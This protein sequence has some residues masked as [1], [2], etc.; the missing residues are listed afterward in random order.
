MPLKGLTPRGLLHL[1]LLLLDGGLLVL[2]YQPACAAFDSILDGHKD[3]KAEVLENNLALTP[4]VGPNKIVVGLSPVAVRMGQRAAQHG[5]EHPART[6]AV[7]HARWIKPATHPR[8][9]D[10]VPGCRS[11]GRAAPLDP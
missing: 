8:L 9:P 7:V 11:V 10:R 5:A 3:P 1:L 2:L 6:S 4:V